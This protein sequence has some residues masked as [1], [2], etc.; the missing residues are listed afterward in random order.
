LTPADA[1]NANLEELRRQVDD[2][3]TDAIALS[4][5]FA[6][7]LLAR[8]EAFERIREQRHAVDTHLLLGSRVEDIIDEVE[9]AEKAGGL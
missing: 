8:A 9:A 2:D 6:R 4:K 7:E 5:R 1:I 3:R